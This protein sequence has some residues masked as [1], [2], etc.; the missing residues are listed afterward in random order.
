MKDITKVLEGLLD[1]NFDVSTDDI[2][3]I[4][5]IIRKYR[6][7]LLTPAISG[8]H[9]ITS[10]DYDELD[11]FVSNDVIMKNLGFKEA[12]RFIL[13]KKPAIVIGEYRGS[14][15]IEIHLSD[16]YRIKYKYPI[17]YKGE[18]DT[19]IADVIEFRK[20]GFGHC[21]AKCENQSGFIAMTKIEKIW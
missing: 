9:D 7:D 1:D 10:Q 12:S 16:K 3:P 17:K 20:S 5:S 8:D 4:I 18:S 6:D 15:V 2:N 11:E 21:Q 14:S 13:P 19:L